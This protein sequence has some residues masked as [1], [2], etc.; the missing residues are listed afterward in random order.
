MAIRAELA[1]LLLRTGSYEE[2]AATVADPESAPSTWQ[3]ARG[4]AAALAKAIE[5]AQ[6]DATLSDE[7]RAALVDAWKPHVDR[8]LA[9]AVQQCPAT[10]P[11]DLNGLAWNLATGDDPLRFDPR[12][13][14]TAVELAAK[15]VAL[16]P[17][18]GDI[19]NTLGVARYRAGEWKGAIA[20]LEK[21]IELRKG[22]D[23]NDWFFLAMAHW[24][25]GYKDEARRWYERGVEWMDKN[26]P[27]NETLT[28]FRAE[29]A[30]L[31]DVSERNKAR[32]FTAPTT[33]TSQP[34]KK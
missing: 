30:E 17:D 19:R 7:R 15:A 3:A 8:L 21:S 13:A 26:D 25:L 5:T 2:A 28:R 9:S 31:L 16:S 14:G 27:T 32:P 34:L 4:A 10:S 33:A 18:R 24:Q 11:N 20:D 29:A 1:R 6:R 12:V 23:S 22:G